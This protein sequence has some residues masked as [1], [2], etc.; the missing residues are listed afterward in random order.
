MKCDTGV[1]GKKRCG[2]LWTLG[3]L[4]IWVLLDPAARRR[5]ESVS[6]KEK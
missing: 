4:V 1:T 3:L 2:C 5:R 6:G